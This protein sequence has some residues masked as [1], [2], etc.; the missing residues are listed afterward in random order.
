M[1]S[2]CK[3]V[4]GSCGQLLILKHLISCCFFIGVDYVFFQFSMKEEDVNNNISDLTVMKND[5]QATAERCRE[6]FTEYSSKREQV[7]EAMVWRASYVMKV[8][9]TC[10]FLVT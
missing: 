8:K 4:V 5:L 6:I 10:R 9:V 3:A 2:F 1:C 7:S